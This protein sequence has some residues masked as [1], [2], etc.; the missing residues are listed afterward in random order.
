MM[1]SHIA[2]LILLP[3]F[4]SFQKKGNISFLFWQLL[5]HVYSDWELSVSFE[6]SSGVAGFWCMCTVVQEWHTSS[7]VLSRALGLCLSQQ[8]VGRG[9]QL[10]GSGIGWDLCNVLSLCPAS[11]LP[12]SP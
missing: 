8:G 12:L 3:T 6:G 1:I 9:L 5:V 4:F 10:F 2:M 11:P 7:E